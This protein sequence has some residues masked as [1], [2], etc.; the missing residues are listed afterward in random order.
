[1]GTM[2]SFN[3]SNHWYGYSYTYLLER[4]VAYDLDFL[5]DL[6]DQSFSL[7]ALTRLVR[8]S[9]IMD[10]GYDDGFSDCG[11]DILYRAKK[12]IKWLKKNR[13]SK[14]KRQLKNLI[15]KKHTRTLY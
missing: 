8:V 15:A 13:Q 3:L 14:Y 2:K 1:M 12:R 9:D 11:N 7:I 10:G 6:A 5:E 4:A